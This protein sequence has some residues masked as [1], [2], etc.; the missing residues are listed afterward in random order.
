MGSIDANGKDHYFPA[1]CGSDPRDAAHREKVKVAHPLRSR[2]DVDYGWLSVCVAGVL[3][4]DDSAC[5][6]RLRRRREIF[7]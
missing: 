1:D 4:V 7:G 3:D 6:G 2:T 5:F